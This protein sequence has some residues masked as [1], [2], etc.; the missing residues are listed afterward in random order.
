MLRL[1]LKHFLCF[2]KNLPKGEIEVP[3]CV[4]LIFAFHML[5]NKLH[6]DTCH[7]DTSHTSSYDLLDSLV[8]CE[9]LLLILDCLRCL[10][11]SI[12]YLGLLRDDSWVHIMDGLSLCI[13][14]L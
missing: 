3:I 9:V 5:N 14:W 8:F 11:E 1:M 2:S 12:R 10:E 7:R 6:R 13:S 4:G